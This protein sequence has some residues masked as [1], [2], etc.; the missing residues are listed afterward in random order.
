MGIHITFDFPDANTARAQMMAFLGGVPGVGD[1]RT[2]TD[3]RQ[4]EMFPA[5]DAEIASQMAK[6][7]A[8]AAA[9]AEGKTADKPKRAPR[10]SAKVTDVADQNAAV[11]AISSGEERIDPQTTATDTADT[12]PAKVEKKLLTLDDVRGA[13]KPYIDKFTMAAASQDLT[14][15]LIAATGCK[16]ISELDGKGQDVLQKA[17]DAFTA[18]GAADTR[19]GTAV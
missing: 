8:E 17:I 14:P 4:A 9:A 15:C 12:A 1:A 2:S 16:A 10:G 18:A 5:R 19:Y 11:P 7:A 13:A 6:T 3:E